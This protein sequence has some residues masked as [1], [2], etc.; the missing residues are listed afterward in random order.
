MTRYVTAVFVF[1]VVNIDLIDALIIHLG[2]AFPQVQNPEKHQ[3]MCVITL[4][5]YTAT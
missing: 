2:V 3:K 5:V 4:K 1:V